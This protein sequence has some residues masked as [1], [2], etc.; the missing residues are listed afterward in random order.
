MN[1]PTDAACEKVVI[2]QIRHTVA[3]RHVE[4]SRPPMRLTKENWDFGN[5]VGYCLALWVAR[6][7]ELGELTVV[8]PESWWQH[9]KRDV[10]GRHLP[11][12]CGWALRRWPVRYHREAHLAAH[13][14]PSCELP[15]DLQ[16][17]EFYTWRRKHG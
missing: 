8:W 9:F 16:E 1:V 11:T 14:L 13:Y 17:G 15:K 7:P 12:F 4:L 3:T 10:L 6:L 5:Q 2:E